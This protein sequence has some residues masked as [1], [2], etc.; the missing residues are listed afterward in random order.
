MHW[1]IRMSFWKILYSNL[2]QKSSM[3]CPLNRFISFAP[4]RVTH[5]RLSYEHLRA[6]IPSF[7]LDDL[8]FQLLANSLRAW[9]PP[10][11]IWF[12]C[13][14]SFPMRKFLSPSLLFDQQS[15]MK[16]PF[17]EFSYTHVYIYIYIYILLFAVS[18]LLPLV[19]FCVC[20]ISA[21]RCGT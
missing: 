11:F 20:V 18:N 15:Q 17:L 16:F 8:L 10:F 7:Q 19:F 14:F 12:S 2:Q 5:N 4:V 13:Y 21:S 9:L 3:I 1:K 6:I